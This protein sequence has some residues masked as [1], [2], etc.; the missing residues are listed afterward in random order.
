MQSENDYDQEVY[1][2]ERV[3]RRQLTRAGE[4]TARST[5]ERHLRVRE[6]DTL[7]R[8]R[9]AIHMAGIETAVVIQ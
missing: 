4:L 3:R 9:N 7:V 5:G 2:G 6:S 1:N 8:L